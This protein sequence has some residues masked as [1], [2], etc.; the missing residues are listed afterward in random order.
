[1]H[2]D[3]AAPGRRAGPA[4]RGRGARGVHRRGVAVHLPRDHD[5]LSRESRRGARAQ[6][7]LG[8]AA[9]G[10][11][12]GAPPDRH[13]GPR[14]RGGD[15]G[16]PQGAPAVAR[17]EQRAVARDRRCRA[18]GA[19]LEVR[20]HRARLRARPPVRLGLSV[21][22][23]SRA[24]LLVADRSRARPL[25]GAALLRF[26]LDRLRPVHGGGVRTLH[27]E[28][29]EVAA[30]AQPRCRGGQPRFT[31]VVQRQE[32][33]RALHRARLLARP[34]R[35]RARRRRGGPRVRL[36]RRR[37]GSGE[38]AGERDQDR[39]L[40]LRGQR[41]EG[42]PLRRPR[43]KA[44]PGAPGRALLDQGHRVGPEPPRGPTPD[45]PAALRPGLPHV[46]RRGTRGLGGATARQE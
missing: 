10:L 2:P 29:D 6:P 19:R 35:G 18:D 17:L 3:R 26:G 23:G 14:R 36:E 5:R 8:R 38:G 13:A 16:G 31:A 7:H 1:M 32:G 40:R 28:R 41:R 27:D 34:E 20:G 45:R 22:R 11:P 4:G 46:A 9:C 39:A 30:P 33:I 15:R 43:C 42:E 44:S 24:V 21:L 37:G 12:F 25:P